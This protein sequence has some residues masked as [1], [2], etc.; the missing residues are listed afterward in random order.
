MEKKNEREIDKTET[1]V[2]C[3]VVSVK[4]ECGRHHVGQTFTFKSG[5][6]PEG[7]CVGAMGAILTLFYSLVYGAEFPWE[8]DKNKFT[9]G[10]L[11]AKNCVMFELE[12]L[13]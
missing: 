11:D 7:I 6:T 13:N 2:K 9:V 1:D 4:G 12:K 5:C 3:T 8:P 10:C